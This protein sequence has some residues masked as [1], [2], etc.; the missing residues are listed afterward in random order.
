MRAKFVNEDFEG[1]KTVFPKWNASVE[2]TVGSVITW[3]NMT[4]DGSLEEDSLHAGLPVTKGVKY[5]LVIWVRE[6]PHN[7]QLLN[8]QQ[9]PI[10]FSNAIRSKAVRA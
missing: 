1:G 5:I 8:Q 4:I 2:P 10:Q 3:R 7:Q 6:N 9:K